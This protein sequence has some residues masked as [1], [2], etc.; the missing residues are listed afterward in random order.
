MK[1]TDRVINMIRSWLRIEAAQSS[2]ITINERLDFYGNAIKNS[3]WYRGKSEEL[4][5]L[6]R[7]I[8][9]DNTTFWRA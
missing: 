8:P 1:I 9:S 5:E 7:Q 3:I 2:Q 6:Y 4:T